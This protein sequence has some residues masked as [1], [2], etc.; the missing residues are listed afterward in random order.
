LEDKEFVLSRFPDSKAET[1]EDGGVYIVTSVR[2]QY[3]SRAIVEVDPEPDNEADAWTEVANFIRSAD[4]DRAK[5]YMMP[6]T[7]E[8]WMRSFSDYVPPE[9]PGGEPNLITVVVE[10]LPG[11]KPDDVAEELVGALSKVN[12]IIET[13]EIK[14]VK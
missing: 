12:G 1:G 11:L 8:D 9:K 10:I 3:R 13:R 14:E 7:K 2:G 5:S 4:E 6:L